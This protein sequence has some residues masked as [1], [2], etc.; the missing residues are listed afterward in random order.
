M[1]IDT[2]Y[3]M[4]PSLQQYFVDKDTGFPL[5]N[6]EVYFF[7][8]NNR[9]NAKS[10]YE[11]SGSP[12]NYSF[13]PIGNKITL[14]SV[15]T[16]EDGSGNDFIPY[17]FPEDAEGNLQ[18]YYVEVYS[19]GGPTGG[20]LQFT[21]EAWPPEAVTESA[22]NGQDST[23]NLIPN[24]QFALHN[25]IGANIVTGTPTGRITSAVTQIAPGGWTFERP[26][27]SLAIDTVTFNRL[28]AYT[29]NPTASP[30]YEIVIQSNGGSPSDAFK[31]L[32]KKFNDVNKFASDTQMYSIFFSARSTSG[33]SFPISFNIIKNYGTGGDPE[34]IINIDDFTITPTQQNFTVSFLWG[35]NLGK[36]IGPSDDD[37]CELAF[38]MPVDISFSIVMTDFANL[39]G[40]TTITEFPISTDEDFTDRSLVPPIPGF[41]AQSWGLP[42]IS[43]EK[44]IDY[45]YSQIGTFGITSSLT[46]P[47]YSILCYGD[48]IRTDGF[49]NSGVPCSRLRD[50]LLDNSVENR[51]VPY[52]GTGKDYV[53][54]RRLSQLVNA[55]FT[56]SANSAGISAPASDGAVPTGF[57]FSRVATGV[58]NSDVYALNSYQC[59]DPLTLWVQSTRAGTTVASS[60]S[61][62]SNIAVAGNLQTS[63]TSPR[64]YCNVDIGERYGTLTVK[65]LIRPQ[66]FGLPSPSSYML[67]T[68]PTGINNVVF[69]FNIN[70]VGTVPAVPGTN[71]YVQVNLTN[72]YSLPDIGFTLSRAISGAEIGYIFPV[73][74]SSIPPNSYFNF[75]VGTQRYYVWY[76]LNNLGTDPNIAGAIGIK[77]IYSISANIDDISY[78]TIVAINRMYY[79]IPDLRGWQ[80][81][82]YDNIGETENLALRFRINGDG[83]NLF[84]GRYPGS[85]AFESQLGNVISST[86]PT[87]IPPA[88][89]PAY[90]TGPDTRLSRYAP[91]DYAGTD[92]LNTKNVYLNYFIKY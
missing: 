55:P 48:T 27:T 43:T 88:I 37:F 76:S 61:A 57:Q 86:L 24:G 62:A 21:R 87:G 34:E 67:I 20:R 5:A 19:A 11:I 89:Y 3:L 74:G 84:T 23:L 42:I 31:D 15:G 18:L 16:P 75:F 92:Q 10:V 73:A 60:T 72:Y 69:W 32:R 7:E 68:Q 77:V 53:T 66:V 1:T 41:N 90:P 47:K 2:R 28:S 36:T 4:S 70:G 46:A 39:I 25:N 79:G 82:G 64:P 38:S 56:I 9:S 91:S 13:T 63:S 59:E 49:F 80:V 50:V 52:F 29:D 6:G 83:C 58:A 22:N 17:L 12:P 26:T 54:A 14:S 78:A 51:G 40:E 35:S 8:D 44:G 71:T 33:G 45:D 65:F 85:Y 30:R 81:K